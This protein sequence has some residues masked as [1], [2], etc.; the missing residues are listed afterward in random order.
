ML[1]YMLV[2]VFPVEQ[3]ERESISFCIITTLVAVFHPALCVNKHIP[4][5]V[6]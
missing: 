4:Q 1:H 3:R 2:R 5:E 6:S